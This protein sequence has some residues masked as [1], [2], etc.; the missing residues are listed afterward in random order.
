MNRSDTPNSSLNMC[1]SN[2]QSLN[3]SKMELIGLELAP[4]F[5]IICLNETNLHNNRQL[6]FSLDI[7]GYQPIFR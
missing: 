6:D 7:E 1:T 2:V 4:D 3:K 5:D